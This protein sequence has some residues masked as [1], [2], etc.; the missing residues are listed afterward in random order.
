M[1]LEGARL[2]ESILIQLIF[3]RGEQTQ[4]EEVLQFV[5]AILILAWVVITY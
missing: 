5:Q 3:R 1:S 2:D 4:V